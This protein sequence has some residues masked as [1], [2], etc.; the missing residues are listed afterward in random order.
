MRLDSFLSTWEAIQG[1]NRIHRFLVSGLLL[2]NVLT[3]IA[4][5]RTDRTVV[6]IPP[7]IQ[8]E[9][10]L[11][12]RNASSS[13]KESWGLYIAELIGNVTPANGEFIEKSLGPLL[14]PG[15]YRSVSEALSEQ[16]RAL[17]MDR[18]AVSFKPK[19][20]FY[21]QETDKIFVTGDHVTQG[22]N[23]HP[24]IQDRTYEFRI[25]FKDYRPLLDSI[26]VY[27]DEPRTLEH[28][29][30]SPP[31]SNTPQRAS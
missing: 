25:L 3:A 14:A 27:T 5:L 9:V 31:V 20:V 10:E 17:K 22:P 28:L 16:I 26:D 30:V 19:Q 29:K 18:V 6:L 8:G 12:R 1:E 7:Q 15:I 23:S 13:L 2:T 24:E 4:V 11:S 21:E